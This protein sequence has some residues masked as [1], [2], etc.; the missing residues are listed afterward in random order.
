MHAFQC[1]K[2]RD[3]RWVA[4]GLQEGNSVLEAA[5]KSVKDRG[6]NHLRLTPIGERAVAAV[7]TNGVEVRVTDMGR[8]ARK[9]SQRPTCGPKG[10]SQIIKIYYANGE[11]F[12]GS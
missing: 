11:P 10:K 9:G 4:I 3:G 7:G 1:W 6:I 8:I 12:K 2:Q 5:Q